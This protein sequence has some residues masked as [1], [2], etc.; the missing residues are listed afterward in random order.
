[1][2]ESFFKDPE[3]ATWQAALLAPTPGHAASLLAGYYL[4]DQP[5]HELAQGLLH[6]ALAHA[7]SRRMAGV[8]PSITVGAYA[9]LHM[10]DEALAT[11]IVTADLLAPAMVNRWVSEPLHKPESI[12][13]HALDHGAFAFAT[14][15]GDV[16]LLKPAHRF[17]ALM[18]GGNGALKAGLR[19]G[20]LALRSAVE[21]CGDPHQ[22]RLRMT[23]QG[24]GII[25]A[26]ARPSEQS[27]TPLVYFYTNRPPAKQTPAPSLARNQRYAA[28]AVLRILRA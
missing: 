5:Q 26:L 23:L 22:A 11:A 20:A 21:C 13:R 10:A 3:W 15:Q 2:I 18:P 1:M 8:E 25:A 9:W 4:K 12:A 24:T 28:L 14:L 27:A 19:A 7:L 17:A 16:T 6:R